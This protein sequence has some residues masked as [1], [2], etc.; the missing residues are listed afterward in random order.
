MS[1]L[2]VLSLIIRVVSSAKRMQSIEVCETKSLM[3]VKNSKGP[4]IEHCG[5]PQV[6]VVVV[7]YFYPASDLQHGTVHYSITFVNN[8][9]T[10]YVHMDTIFLLSCVNPVPV[11]AMRRCGNEK[12]VIPVG[13]YLTSSRCGVRFR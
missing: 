2:D 5:T 9:W 12:E 11:G 6:V 4:R 3:Y 13:M 10:Y 8:K 7:V 1:E